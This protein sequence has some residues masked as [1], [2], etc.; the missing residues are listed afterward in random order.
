MAKYALMI[1]L[2]LLSNI[3]FAS[4]PHNA[5][6]Y[7]PLVKQD[8]ALV[9]PTIPLK[10]T[11]P[12][13][14]EQESCVSLTSKR[15]WNPRTELKT[16]REYGFGLGQLTNTKQFNNFNAIKKQDVRLRSWKWSDRYNPKYQ[17]IALMDMDK[18]AWNMA[19]FPTA[20]PEE[21]LAFTFAGYNGGSGGVL[22]DHTLCEHTRGCNPK[23]WWGN[24]EKTSFKKKTKIHGYG[25]SFFQ[26]NRTYVINIMKVRRG[27]YIPYVG[28]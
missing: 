21:R 19:R 20:S 9:W 26:I 5:K 15:C 25:Q 18:N 1:V 8:I 3:S 22:Q 13:Q 12:S 4:I 27:K 11:I 10:S 16:S 17:V 28:N 24:V 14:V 7:L 6:I 2:L 23:K